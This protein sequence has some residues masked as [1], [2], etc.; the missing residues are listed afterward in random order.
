MSE[1]RAR[2]GGDARITRRAFIWNT[3]SGMVNAAQSA[4]TL[5]FISHFLTHT[6]A[7]MFT[8]AFALANLFMTVGKY[9]VRNYQVTD[10]REANRFGEYR[11]ARLISVIGAL[12]AMLAYL[13]FQ[14]TKGVYS[15]GKIGVIAAIGLW[16]LIDAVED[17]YYG[18]YQQRGR[19]DIGARCYALRLIASTLLL[20]ALI[21]A[22]VPL[23]I[24]AGITLLF[25]AALAAWLVKSTLG[26]FHLPRE[27]VRRDAVRRILRVC[28]P[29]FI[30]TTLSIFVCNAPKYMIDWHMDE[31]TQA[32]FGYIMM[33]AFVIVVL[34]Q[35]IY[36]P[37]L[38]GLGELWQGG[39]KARFVR[40]VL[41]QYLAVLG[42]TLVVIA[43][44]YVAGIPVLSLLYNADLTPYK[45]EFLLLLLGGGVYAL[46]DFM[47]A[48]LTAMRFQACIPFGFAGA[49][50]L[51]VWLGGIIVPATG[52]MGAARLYLIL[53]LALVA[54]LT[55]CF[56]I[57]SMKA[58]GDTP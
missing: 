5:I 53:N 44:G 39:D 29:L 42:V 21:A 33:P 46:A 9:G 32:I 55:A 15:A 4:V 20:C 47:M 28:L 50:A 31:A 48:T 23:L 25:S 1:S 54:Y 18:M 51:S 7:G 11:R 41:L 17:V 2:A 13:A 37:I 26:A 58:A 8:I 19:L 34:N 52:M 30:G 3:A 24:A 57:R 49:A 45:A 27:A 38:R 35:F 10:V 14:A 40:R 43:G 12:A 56:L 16:K 36:Q 22:R 6:D